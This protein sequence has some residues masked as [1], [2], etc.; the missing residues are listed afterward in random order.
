MVLYSDQLVVCDSHKKLATI[1]KNVVQSLSCVRLCDPMD[2]S[3]PGL[4]VLH[5]LLELVQTHVY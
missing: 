5:H 4:P 2:S 3:M 1:I